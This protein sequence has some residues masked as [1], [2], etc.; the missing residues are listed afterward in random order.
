MLPSLYPCYAC[1]AHRRRVHTTTWQ[2]RIVPW[3]WCKESQKQLFPSVVICLLTHVILVLPRHQLCLCVGDL[4]I[5]SDAGIFN[6]SCMQLCTLT[7]QYVLCIDFSFVDVPKAILLV[8]TLFSHILTR[9]LARET[10]I[11]MSDTSPIRP[12][13]LHPHIQGPVQRTDEGLRGLPSASPVFLPLFLAA[14][15][16]R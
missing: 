5:S 10:R 4:S 1:F 11:W 13:K 3:R 15:P 16:C 8:A 14:P 12:L 9:G 6:E 2:S 7:D